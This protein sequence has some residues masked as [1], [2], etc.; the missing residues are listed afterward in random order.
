MKTGVPRRW[1]ALTLLALLL[2]SPLFSATA[3][4][5][6]VSCKDPL[7]SWNAGEAKDRILAFVRS[8]TQPGSPAFVPVQERIAVFDNDGTLCLE[9][10]VPFQF[11]F[12]FE[13]IRALAEIDTELA[14]QQPYKAVIDGDEVTLHNLDPAEL[15]QTLMISFAGTTI[16]SFQEAVNSWLGRARHPRYQRLYT[17]LVY[18]PM[19]ELLDYLRTNDF[20]IFV[21]S[22]SGADFI[23]VF[24]GT[25]YGI[26]VER[27]IGSSL[28]YE[29]EKTEGGQRIIKTDKLNSYN[30]DGEKVL[31]IALHIGRKP[32]LAFGNSDS[33][34]AMLE[35]TDNGKGPGLSL[36]LHHDDE[37]REY[38]YAQGAERAVETARSRG[39]QIVG[40]ARD[41]KYVFPFELSQTR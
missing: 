24:S 13:R 33:D 16:E 29:L 6:M 25:L 19:M 41:F 27:V 9:K 36:L 39:W 10:P 35:Y 32:I 2:T 23:R 12:S 21:V 11:A 7:P 15:E 37:T 40:M 31:N 22:G 5:A 18:Q 1:F 8:V 38:L 34:L 3:L 28:V 30:V 4:R 14:E 17:E 26:P 20:R